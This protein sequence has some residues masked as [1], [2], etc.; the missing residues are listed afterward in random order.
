MDG[1]DNVVMTRTFSKIFGLGGIRLGWAYGPAAIIDALN[2]VRGPFNVSSPA[3]AAGLAALDDVAF[4]DKA[5]AHNAT[6]RAW[7]R[8]RLM[9]LG[10]DVPRSACNFVLVRFPATPGRDARA[11]DAF[12]KERGIIVRRVAAYG[13]PDC[14]RVTIGR[15]DEMRALAGALKEFME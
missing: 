11:A 15:E 13:L 9:A 4:T 3:L 14:L 7:A 8:E 6:W 12:L 2:R 5:R 10:L 1:N